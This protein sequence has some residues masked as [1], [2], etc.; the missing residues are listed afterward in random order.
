MSTLQFDQPFSIN[1]GTSYEREIAAIKA[2]LNQDPALTQWAIYYEAL[3][4]CSQRHG[5]PAGLVERYQ[6]EAAKY[7]Q[8]SRLSKEIK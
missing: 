8:L 7:W 6:Q 3:A 4:S 5:M 1:V 2:I